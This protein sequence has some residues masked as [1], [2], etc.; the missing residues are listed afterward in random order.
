M[1]GG[2][3][4]GTHPTGSPV[5]HLSLLLAL[6]SPLAGCASRT[7][8]FGRP[9][10]TASPAYR[11]IAETT[12]DLSALYADLTAPAVDLTEAERELQRRIWHFRAPVP[13]WPQ[14]GP[15]ARANAIT[16]RIAGD[17]ENFVTLSTVLP[18]VADKDR[19]R[20]E[21]LG[22]FSD[23][24]PK[25]RDMAIARMAENAALRVEICQL[26]R[27]RAARYRSDL[28]ALVV[29]APENEVVPA[30]RRLLAFEAAIMA[31][32]DMG[33][34]GQGHARGQGQK[35]QGSGRHGAPTDLRAP[36]TRKG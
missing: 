36:L 35:G 24:A 18:R 5:L 14:A 13:K 12:P 9:S 4:S 29:A 20:H 26:V 2:V 33:D 34:G 1:P 15:T 10:P 22:A 11:F 30:E 3:P 17:H 28:Q 21:A 16:D 27:I 19:I 31:D 7:G 25:A 6:A 32:C 23:T 8:D